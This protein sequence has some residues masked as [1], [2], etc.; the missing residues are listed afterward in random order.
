MA[1]A[2]QIEN[3]GYGSDDGYSSDHG[4]D[5]DDNYISRGSTNQRTYL[6]LEE[7][8]IKAYQ[9]KKFTKSV[10]DVPAL[11]TTIVVLDDI[12]LH[13]TKAIID[14]S[15]NNRRITIWVVE[16]ECKQVL[17]QV[18]KLSPPPNIT[19]NTHFGDVGEWIAQCGMPIHAFAADFCGQW[20]TQRSCI[21]AYLQNMQT[22]NHTCILWATFS[23]RNKNKTRMDQ[24][25]V[26]FESLIYYHGVSLLREQPA[27]RTTRYTHA[28]DCDCIGVT[29]AMDSKIFKLQVDSSRKRR[30]PTTNERVVKPR[31]V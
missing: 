11:E 17:L 25:W 16:N 22:H 13:T 6:V 4:G 30:A 8:A 23:A 20:Q 14:A 26:E 31:I 7:C 15:N 19:I 1:I 21:D 9:N 10:F 27:Y 12:S 2:Q 24:V 18:R 29:Q 5:D 28:R 3:G